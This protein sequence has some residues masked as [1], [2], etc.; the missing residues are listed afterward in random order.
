MQSVQCYSATSYNQ[1]SVG[2]T[3][4]LT[5]DDLSSLILD[6]S[7]APSG[8]IVALSANIWRKQQQVWILNNAPLKLRFNA[9]VELSQVQFIIM[10]VTAVNNHR[11]HWY[12]FSL[13]FLQRPKHTTY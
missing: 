5:G 10:S 7:I 2:G 1:V 6:S 9:R 3:N 8:S 13:T 11:I 12:G 4:N